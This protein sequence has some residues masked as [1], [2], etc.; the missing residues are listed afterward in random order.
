MYID[1]KSYYFYY[2]YSYLLYSHGGEIL[3]AKIFT[4]G[5]KNENSLIKFRGSWLTVQDKHNIIPNLQILFLRILGHATMKSGKILSHKHFPL[6][7][8]T[9]LSQ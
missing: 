9:L 1:I 7:G 5:F 4:G 2:Y 3:G 6:Y 8:N